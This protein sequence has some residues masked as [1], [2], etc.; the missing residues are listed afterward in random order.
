MKREKLR[1]TLTTIIVLEL[2]SCPL[3][4]CRKA[5]TKGLSQVI[6]DYGDVT[7]ANA[8]AQTRKL[9]AW[10]VVQVKMRIKSKLELIICGIKVS[11]TICESEIVTTSCWFFF[12]LFFRCIT[13]WAR[14]MGGRFANSLYLKLKSSNNL[15][16]NPPLLFFKNGYISAHGWT[17][18]S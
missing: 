15:D 2:F 6:V 13:R 12:T 8:S 18:S 1:K 9:I 10:L 11:E 17:F 5:L 4:K 16:N 14:L 3:A 7:Y